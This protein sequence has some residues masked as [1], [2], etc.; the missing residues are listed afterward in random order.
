MEKHS[1]TDES[2]MKKA[3][4]LAETAQ[5]QGEVPVGALIVKDNEIIGRGCNQ[6]IG[7]H[8]ATAHA[9]I[10]AIRDAGKVMK[11]YRLPGTTMY[12]T[13]EP[14]CMCVGAIIHARIDRLVFGASDPKTGAVSGQFE[15]L[16]DVAHNHVTRVSGGCLQQ[17]SSE[18]L[19]A[20][21]R[22]RR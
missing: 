18:M 9:E 10:C 3:L 12:V 16:S 6:N 15:L 4:E 13:L 7:T 2:W 1:H 5:G 21:F 22:E 20:F 8:D 11:N 17:E 14:C 19:K